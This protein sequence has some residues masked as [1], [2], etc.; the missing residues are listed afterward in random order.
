MKVSQGIHWPEYHNLHSK[1]H[2]QNLQVGPFKTDHFLSQNGPTDG[3]RWATQIRRVETCLDIRWS[4][5]MTQSEG[6]FHSK[7]R[8]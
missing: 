6:N 5:K 3:S 8:G 1:K 4:G 7:T 2:S